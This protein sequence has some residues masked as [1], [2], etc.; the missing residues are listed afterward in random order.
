[1]S[2]LKRL[3]ALI[4]L[5][6]PA[7]IAVRCAIAFADRAS[8]PVQAWLDPLLARLNALPSLPAALLAGDYGIVAML[9]FLFLYALPTALLFGLLADAYR[10]AGILD[11]LGR[12]LHP[13]MLKLGL[14]GRDLITINM[15]F[16]CN[17]P[18][19]HAARGCH[20]CTQEA[21]LSAI[22][23]GAAC[24]YQHP[25]SL[26]ILAAAGRA[27]LAPA[28]LSIL[29]VATALFL[30]V[31]Y[32]GPR[33]LAAGLPMPA[34]VGALRAP[35]PMLLIQNTWAQ[36]KDFV[37]DATTVFAGVCA[38]AAFAAWC[39]LL[40]LLDRAAM[41]L[42]SLLGLPAKVGE[43]VVMSA[44]RKNGMATVLV[45][46]QGG[47]RVPMSAPS[48]LLGTVL[49]AGMFLPCVVTSLALGKELGWKRT[50]PLLLRQMGVV[51]ILVGALTWGGRLGGF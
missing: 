38:L 26:A 46:P 18:A 45:S 48:Q 1:M 24:S 19:V 32:G 6:L 3:G 34:A 29:V 37:L 43:A 47:L 17:V 27:D 40:G 44:V 39:G 36:L 11:R 33:S 9:P 25:A 12:L 21:C 50:G 30:R 42:M 41:P 8:V 51:L 4:L 5:V 28:Y 35:R 22:A 49:L 23:F 10:Q 16:G 13:W 7:Y 31:F 2:T 20:R 14:D 15:G